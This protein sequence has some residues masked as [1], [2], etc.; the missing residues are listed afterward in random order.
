MASSLPWRRLLVESVA[1]IASI[2]IAFAIDAA[3]DAHQEKQELRQLLEGLRA[4]LLENQDLVQQGKASA[5]QA[6]E[7]LTRFR[8]DSTEV[9][10]LIGTDH[11][12]AGLYLPFVKGWDIAL[13]TGFLQATI[14]SGKL[15]LIPDA[16][17]RALLTSLAAEIEDIDRLN[18]ELDRM[19]AEAATVMG[20]YPSVRQAPDAVEIDRDGILVLRQD[21]RLQGLASARIIFMGGYWFTLDRVVAPGLEE[22]LRA[23]DRSLSA[24]R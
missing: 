11:S 24:L 14:S 7:S 3:W 8:A 5:S 6:M 18:G 12:Y 15:S 1:V 19:G 4:E 16:G 23:I 13:Q 20:E 10:E 22:A 2:L 21:R 17:T 9:M